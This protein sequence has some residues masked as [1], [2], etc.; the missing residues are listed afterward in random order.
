[1][2]GFYRAKSDKP[3]P[4]VIFFH[5]GGWVRGDE[6]KVPRLGEYL[7]AGVSVVSMRYYHEPR[8]R[9]WLK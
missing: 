9:Y 1:M 6:S 5:G 4:V 8:K 3:V 7:R 2:L